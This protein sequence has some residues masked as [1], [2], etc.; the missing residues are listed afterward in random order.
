MNTAPR[1]E[2]R[3]DGSASAGVRHR[4]VRR[5]LAVAG[6][7][8]I[9][10]GT[11]Q[12]T[13]GTQIPDWTGAK[14][15]PVALGL[16]TVAMSLL[17][18]A[19]AWA[20]RDPGQLVPPLAATIPALVGFTT[21]GRLWYLPGPLAISATVIGIR[22]WR[23]A[24]IRAVRAWPRLLLAGLGGCDLVLAAG[25]PP[26]LAVLAAASGAALIGVAVLGSHHLWWAAG[27]LGAG[28]IPFAVAAWAAIVPMLT[29]ALAASLAPAVRQ[30]HRGPS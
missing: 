1:N 27:L 9:L 23:S 18:I 7:L 22:N 12:A 24:G 30:V 5:L 8:G 6:V 3:S 2:H 14:A 13:F 21:V 26:A 25:A 20:W 28:T 19:C 11:I 15:E 17:M 10:A 29:L 4:S 16:L